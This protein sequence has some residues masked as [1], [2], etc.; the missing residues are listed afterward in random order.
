MVSPD[1]RISLKGRLILIALAV[2]VGFSFLAFYHFLFHYQPADE[3]A[4]V[5]PAPAPAPP[6]VPALA[7]PAGP[8]FLDS[9]N[10][11]PLS[12]GEAL[13]RLLG[14][15]EAGSTAAML[16]V[17][18][19]YGNGW[20]ARQNFTERFQ[21]LQKAAEAGDP[22]GIFRAGLALELGLGIPADQAAAA[23]A[24]EQAADLGLPEAHFKL[25]QGLLVGPEA[26][27]ARAAAHLEQAL[28]GGLPP[29]ANLLGLLYLQGLGDLTADAGKAR[30]ALQRGAELADPE[31]LKNL[32]VMF[33]EGWGGPADPAQALK[34][35]LAA[36]EAG[37]SEGDL[38]ETLAELESR[39][40]AQAARD[41]EAEAR[42]WLAE[43]RPGQNHLAQ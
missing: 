25:A 22:L 34:W 19:F 18:E 24:F 31:A 36:R 11:N 5:P 32:A 23:R 27:P 2:A 6:P 29:A 9:N 26:A 12:P 33:K 42:A 4:S 20:G 17:A 13:E 30:Q 21:W 41:A 40:G 15:A 28:A 14:A 8:A 43:R 1:D 39:V 7:L 37:W 3:T 38:K 10:Q 16:N 35:Y